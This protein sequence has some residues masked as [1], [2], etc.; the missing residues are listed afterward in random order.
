MKHLF[1]P[2][3]LLA[4]LLLTACET[5]AQ[6]MAGAS[7]GARVEVIDF[8]STHRCKSCLAIENA[9]RNVV[10]TEFATEKKAG[11]ILFKTVNVDDAQNAKIAEQFEASGTALFVY[12]T[13]TGEVLDLTDTG[14]S[15]A[16]NDEARFKEFLRTAI[17]QTL[18]KL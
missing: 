5:E 9:A 14:F 10:E 11:K 8:Y 18:A 13:K 7:G 1:A 3:F 15:Y 17:R 2:L 12:N 16:M 6:K 4:G